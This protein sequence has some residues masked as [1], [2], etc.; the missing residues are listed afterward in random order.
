[1]KLRRKRRA[2]PPCTC[3]WPQVVHGTESGEL[4]CLCGGKV[5]REGQVA[6][7]TA[8]ALALMD[9]LAY[10]AWAETQ[11]THIE[12]AQGG[13]VGHMPWWKYWPWRLLWQLGTRPRRLSLGCRESG[14][15]EAR[16]ATT[17][18]SPVFAGLSLER[19]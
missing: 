4:V 14:Q 11:G 10:D 5:S 3:P 17:A 9:R 2:L 6:V 13:V 12:V 19:P 16:N 15:Q 18:E 8:E 1:V 7:E